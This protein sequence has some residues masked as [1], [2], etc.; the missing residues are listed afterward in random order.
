MFGQNS[1]AATEFS[2]RVSAALGLLDLW[3]DVGA[4]RRAGRVYLPAEDLTAFGVRETDLDAARASPA[5]RDTPTSSGSPCSRPTFC[6]M[7]ANTCW[8]GGSICRAMS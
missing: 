1:T 7:C 5:L 3:Q 4:D 2:D 8:T 6:V